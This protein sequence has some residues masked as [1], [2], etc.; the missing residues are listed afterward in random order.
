MMIWLRGPQPSAP[1]RCRQYKYRFPKDS[2]A[3][4]DDDDGD[5]GMSYLPPAPH[6]PAIPARARSDLHIC[7]RGGRSVSKKN[8]FCAADTDTNY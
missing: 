3:S 2:V 5:A 8:M 6:R 1:F 7:F 4:K